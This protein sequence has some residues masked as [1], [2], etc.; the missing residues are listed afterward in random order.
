MLPPRA[1]PPSLRETT[2][3]EDQF[4]LPLITTEAITT[5]SQHSFSLCFSGAKISVQNGIILKIEMFLIFFLQRKEH[6]IPS[7][8]FNTFIDLH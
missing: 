2:L 5:K 1:A 7:A 4:Y 8:K 6:Q 3:G